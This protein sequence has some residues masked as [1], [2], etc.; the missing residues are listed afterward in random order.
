M[1][2]DINYWAV[3]TAA[4]ISVVLGMLWFGPLFGKQWMRLAGILMPEII[5]KEMQ[6]SMFRSYAITALGA[7][8]QATVFAHLYFFMAEATGVSGLL[9]AATLAFWCWLAFT[10]LPFTGSVLWEG[11]KWAYWTIVSGY[12]LATLVATA[13]VL[14]VWQ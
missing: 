9:T 5:T 12:W 13:I 8:I 3:L 10:A 6:R 14:A 11:K 7:F 4:G 2:V 1:E